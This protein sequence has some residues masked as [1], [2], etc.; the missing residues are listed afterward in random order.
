M[1]EWSAESPADDEIDIELRAAPDVAS[2]LILVA[3]V[4][5]R[6]FLESRGS[7]NA[8]DERQSD[9]FYLT[10]WLQQERLIDA[11]SPNELEILQTPIGRLDADMASLASWQSEALVALAWALGL[12]DPMPAYHTMAEPGPLFALVPSPWDD[13]SSFAA[14]ARLRDELEVAQERERAE[15]WEWRAQMEEIANGGESREVV[16]ITDTISEVAREAHAAGLLPNPVAGDVAA[17][18]IAYRDLSPALRENAAIVA[19]QRLRAL[20]W[21]CGFGTSWDDVP[22]DP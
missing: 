3:T 6:A 5:R 10:A 18:G 22:L 16:E 21:L 20:N 15:L 12:L 9:R 8:A 13:T 7:G 11:A 17:D 19:G 4:C 1:T 2:R 14:Q